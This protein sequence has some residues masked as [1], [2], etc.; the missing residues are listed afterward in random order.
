M[1]K[2]IKVYL[3]TSV[4]S[5]LFDERNPE[6]RLLT[7]SFFKEIQTF[8]SYI[9]EIVSIEIDKSPN[10]SLQNKMKEISSQ[11]PLLPLTDE[12]EWLANEFI[13]YGAIPEGFPEDAYHIAIAVLNEIDYLLSWNFKH[14]VRRKTRD[15]VRMVNTI[16]GLRQIEILTPAELL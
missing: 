11:L 9:S 2:K 15:I 14:I 16:H 3:D 12:V 6:R 7:Q 13:R 1:K 4:I 8:E 5:A 10:L